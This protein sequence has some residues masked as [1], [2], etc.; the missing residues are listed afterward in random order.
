MFQTVHG[1]SVWPRFEDFDGKTVRATRD[2]VTLFKMP[3]MLLAFINEGDFIHYRDGL[4]LKVHRVVLGEDQHFVLSPDLST[5]RLLEELL[6]D[7]KNVK[8]VS[9][10]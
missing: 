8:A 10:E 6:M 9:N 7:K 2:G 3:K 1:F 4:C 5:S